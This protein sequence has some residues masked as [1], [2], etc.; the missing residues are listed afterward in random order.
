MALWYTNPNVFFWRR[1]NGSKEVAWLVVNLSA[2]PQEARLDG[3]AYPDMRQIFGNAA[4]QLHGEKFVISLP[5]Y[6]SGIWLPKQH[7]SK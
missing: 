3:V 7:S 6:G 4:T 2:Q 1:S 5:P